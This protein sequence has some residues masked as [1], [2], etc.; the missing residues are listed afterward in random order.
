[1]PGYKLGRMLV[2]FAAHTNHCSLY[3]W[4]K[5]VISDHAAELKAFKTSEGTIQFIPERP[6]PATLVRTIV[7]ARI[8]QNA[9]R[10][11][12]AKARRAATRRPAKAPARGGRT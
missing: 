8:A 12:D 7:K 10:D 11:A 2:G 4:S 6:L 1:M 3:P 5:T 9:A